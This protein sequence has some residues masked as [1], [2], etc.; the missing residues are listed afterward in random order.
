MSAEVLS[1]SGRLRHLQLSDAAFI[2]VVV[3]WLVAASLGDVFADRIF[4]FDSALIAANAGS[5]RRSLAT[6][7]VSRLRRSTGSGATT[8]STPR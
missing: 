5:F 3:G 1:S 2:A 4:P 7:G 8:N 6:W